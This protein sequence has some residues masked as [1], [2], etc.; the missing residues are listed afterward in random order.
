MFCL[1]SSMGV[2]VS[3]LSTYGM[4]R[5]SKKYTIRFAPGGP[6]R[7]PLFFSRGCSM[8]TCS[9]GASMKLFMLTVLK[10]QFSESRPRSVSRM[11]AVLPVPALP[12]NM[13]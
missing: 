2:W 10:H 6:K 5:S 12:T 8:I 3:Y 1:A 9:A 4:L 13:Q 7:T 11:S